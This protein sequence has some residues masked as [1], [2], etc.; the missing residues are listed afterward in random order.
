MRGGANRR[1][2][3]LQEQETTDAT[4]RD[5]L[6]APEAR[7][8]AARS[9]SECSSTRRTGEDRDVSVQVPPS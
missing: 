8:A 4:V 1:A 6:P 5:T 2:R 9:R 7:P 3:D